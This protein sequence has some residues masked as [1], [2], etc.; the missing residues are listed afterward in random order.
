[1][2]TR[3]VFIGAGP[4][5]VTAAETLRKYDQDSE[6]IMLSEEPY[7]PYSP[8]AMVDHF[9]S[10]SNAHFWLD[11][12]WM[13]R[14]VVNYRQGVHVQRIEAD[15]KQVFIS[16]GDAIRYDRLVIATGSRL[17]APLEGVDKSGVYNFKS[18][19]AAEG[20]VREVRSG[21]AR[22]AVVVGA[23][24]IGME[25]ALLLREL[26]V[27]VTQVEM[28]DQVMPAMLDA[29]TGAYALELMRQ[30]GVTVHL[31]TKAVAIIGQEQANG[32]L[33]ESGD[34]IEAD[35]FIAATGVRP[36]TELIGG[37]RIAHDWGIL[38][39]DHLQ[40]NDPDIF[41]AGDVISAHDRLTGERYVHANFPNATDQGRVVGLNLA[42]FDTEY[43]GAERMNSLKHL[44]LPIMA[45]GLK[46]GDEILS[47]RSNGSQR[48]IYLKDGFVVGYQLIGDIRAAG[49]LRTLMVRGENVTK[50]KDRLLDH[51]FSQADLTWR[52]M[53]V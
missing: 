32:V 11:D 49:A 38:V 51:N 2:K 27:E 18:L 30:R 6:I 52:A 41:A 48:R 15:E 12:A 17:Y 23:G 22:T 50:F 19:R 8:P 24:F 37:S 42:G 53:T 3:I 35:I 14:L 43:D 45:V 10:N 33:L 26:G 13:D 46:D 29:Q 28:F 16:G 7:P 44:D 1:M 40:T 4:A 31:N 47:A 20:L 9:L 39:D 25:I 21:R 36:N 5:G 34:S